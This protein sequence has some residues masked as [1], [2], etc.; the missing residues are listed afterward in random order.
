MAIKQQ[1]RDLINNAWTDGYV[2]LLATVG[3]DGVRIDA[4]P[5]SNG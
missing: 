3:P 5:V 1:I 4:C 2:C